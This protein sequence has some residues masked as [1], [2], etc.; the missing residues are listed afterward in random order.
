LAGLSFADFGAEKMRNSYTPIRVIHTGVTLGM[1]PPQCGKRFGQMAD[2]FRSNA[3]YWGERGEWFIVAAQHR[4]SDSLTR[5]NFLVM[6]KT[7]G[8]ESDGVAVE[9]A[10]HWAVGWVEY[11]IVSPGNRQRLR[12][13]I[14]AHCAVSDY[15]VLD[16]SH[17][18]ELEYNEAWKWAQR[19]LGEFANWEEAFRNATE[20]TG[21]SDDET[22]RAIEEAR[23][24]L[25]RVAPLYEQ[26][27]S[28]PIDPAQL[29]LFEKSRPQ[30]TGAA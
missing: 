1:N 30:L 27:A 4:D 6:L 24:E 14:L 29:K 2:A 5:S 12:A 23:E 22:W 11:L 3:A 9:R 26:H 10:N 7:L 19:E 8:G 18:S 28:S 13:A 21:F 15:P 25:E 20:N 16:E 17:W